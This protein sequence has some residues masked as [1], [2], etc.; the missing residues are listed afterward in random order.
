MTT[1]NCTADC[2]FQEDGL[3]TLDEIQVVQDEQR[4][5]CASRVPAD[6]EEETT[7]GPDRRNEGP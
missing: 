3:C 4:A 1:V 2:V 5:D 6:D 7:M